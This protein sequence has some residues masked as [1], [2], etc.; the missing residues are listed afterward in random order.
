MQAVLS[1]T[2]GSVDES[3]TG[4]AGS[5]MLYCNNYLGFY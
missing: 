4:A 2:S 5:V 3:V 1:I